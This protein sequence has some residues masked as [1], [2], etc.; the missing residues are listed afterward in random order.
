MF[1]LFRGTYRVEPDVCNRK[2]NEELKDRLTPEEVADLTAVGLGA[3]IT[4]PNPEIKDKLDAILQKLAHNGILIQRMGD[5]TEVA[6][7]SEFMTELAPM[8]YEVMSKLKDPLELFS[9]MCSLL[10]QMFDMGYTYYETYGSF[11][12]KESEVS[13]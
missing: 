11:K 9:A 8:H 6:A 5:L 2:G 4:E 7:F 12:P 3:G 1:V 10:S 13:E